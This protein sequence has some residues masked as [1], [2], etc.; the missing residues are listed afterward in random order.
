MN[1]MVRTHDGATAA[2]TQE[3]LRIAEPTIVAMMNGKISV[4]LAN[5]IILQ[6]LEDAGKPAKYEEK[7]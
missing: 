5:D 4:A 1:I 3:Q 2:L 7:T 6:K